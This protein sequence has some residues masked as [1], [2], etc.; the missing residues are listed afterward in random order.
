MNLEKKVP[1]AMTTP[2]KAAIEVVPYSD[3]RIGLCCRIDENGNPHHAIVEI[4]SPQ[5]ERPN[6]RVLIDVINNLVEG[7][8]EDPDFAEVEDLTSLVLGEVRQRRAHQDQK[9][10]GA[11]HDDL[12]HFQ[13]WCNMIDN[14]LGWARQQ[15][16]TSN[17]VQARRRMIDVAALAVACVETIDRGAQG[18]IVDPRINTKNKEQT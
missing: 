13:A 1:L 15:A 16:M 12:H 2:K 9:W 8:F 11:E 18:P 10:G 5:I 3:D 6:A 7:G 4:V 17:L 14:Y